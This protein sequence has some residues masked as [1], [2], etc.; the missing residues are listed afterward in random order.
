MPRRPYRQNRRAANVDATR[1]RLV[2]ATF[3]LHGERGIAATTMKD[4]AERADVS[5]GTVYHHFATYSEAVKACGAYALGLAP[6]PDKAALAGALSRDERIVRLAGAF[7]DF[8]EKLGAFDWVR[9]DSHVDPLLAAVVEEEENARQ[10][11]AAL[12]LGSRKS[13]RT[14]HVAAMCDVGVFTAF[15]RTGLSAR[16]AAAIVAEMINAWLAAT[17]PPNP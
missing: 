14:R 16:Q 2:K 7:F 12:A 1:Q 6:I 8:Y 3:E 9:R 13:A 11:L 5:V 4:I 15:A 17:D 10:A